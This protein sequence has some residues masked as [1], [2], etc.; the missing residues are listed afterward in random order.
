VLQ[1]AVLFGVAF[2]PFPFRQDGWPAVEVDVG[3]REDVQAPVISLAIVVFD[4]LADA[5]FFQQGD[6]A[7]TTPARPMLDR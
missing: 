3:G 7:A 2:D 4:E 5:G 6:P 1:A